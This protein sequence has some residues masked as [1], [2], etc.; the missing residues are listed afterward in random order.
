MFARRVIDILTMNFWSYGGSVIA[1]LTVSPS[2]YHCL[3]LTMKS[4]YGELTCKCTLTQSVTR[5]SL[6]DHEGPFVW[7]N[8]N[9][10]TEVMRVVRCTA[11]VVALFLHI[12]PPLHWLLFRLL[13]LLFASYFLFL[14]IR[15]LSEW[16]YSPIWSTLRTGSSTSHGS[17]LVLF[18]I[19]KKISK[20]FSVGG[21]RIR[22]CRLLWNGSKWRLQ[23]LGNVCWSWH[24]EV[25]AGRKRSHRQTQQRPVI[26]EKKRFSDQAYILCAIFNT[27]GAVL[28]GYK[29]S[30]LVLFII[31]RN[32]GRCALTWLIMISVSIV[33]LNDQFQVTETIRMGIV[34][35]SVYDIYVEYEPT[36]HTY[37]I[38]PFCQVVNYTGGNQYEDIHD[39]SSFL[40]LSYDPAFNLTT[41]I[42]T[43]RSATFASSENK[44]IMHGGATR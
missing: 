21:L 12:P 11:I 43:M 1:F 13:K 35:V 44:A 42:N 14:T 37:V 29:A 33:S 34:D 28:L 23:W 27:L 9:A 31:P 39:E 16:R 18:C 20:W 4:T 7:C 17:S 6:L 40:T 38:V 25:V 8:W 3:S 36:N 26:A 22:V 32:Y 15:T 10:L 41:V 2:P 19:F 24:S 30:Y 5:I